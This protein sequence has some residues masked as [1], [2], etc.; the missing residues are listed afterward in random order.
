[1][2]IHLKNVASQIDLPLNTPSKA[3]NTRLAQEMG[4]WAEEQGK[5]DE[6]HCAVFQSYFIK[7]QD[8]SSSLVL[9]DIAESIGL[10]GEEARNTI[11]NRTFREEVDA[12]WSY[13]HEIKVTAVPTFFVNQ[14]KLSGAQPYEVLKKFIL[15]NHIQKR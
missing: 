14:K 6:F 13:S 4:K 11:K 10:S 8:I 7:T 12:D 9:I 2:M 15:D 5:G 1:M 3:Y